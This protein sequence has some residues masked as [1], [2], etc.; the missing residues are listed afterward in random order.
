MD[1]AHW[2]SGEGCLDHKLLERTCVDHKKAFIRA[3]PMR[4][5]FM[6]ELPLPPYHLGNFVTSGTISV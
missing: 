5:P 4:N 6:T 3:S 1:F 2:F